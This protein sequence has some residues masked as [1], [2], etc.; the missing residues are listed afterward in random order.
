M[1]MKKRVGIGLKIILWASTLSLLWLIVLENFV[2][3]SFKKFISN[4]ENNFKTFES[5]T[6]KGLEDSSNNFLVKIG[7]LQTQNLAEKS[8]LLL[9]SNPAD[10][11]QKL[12]EIC[13]N[14]L[15]KD[16]NIAYLIVESGNTRVMKFRNEDFRPL[17]SDPAF[18]GDS[19][20][21]TKTQGVSLLL[22]SGKKILEFFA[23]IDANQAPS[24][25]ME[26][27]SNKEDSSKAMDQQT[28]HTS[29]GFVRV[30]MTYDALDCGIQLNQKKLIANTHEMHAEL[31]QAVHQEQNKFLGIVVLMALIILLALY[32]LISK[33]LSPFAILLRATQGI[34]KGNLG[35]K[36]EIY[37][38]DEIGDLA[39]NFNKMIENLKK[40]ILKIREA[41][42]RIT[43]TAHQI[44]ASSDE[45]AMGAS[46]QSSSV[47]E[48]TT[49]VEELANTAS[50]ISDNTKSVVLIADT[51][52]K[53]ARDG[54]Q[55]ITDALH[56]IEDAKEKVET[57]AKKIL[58]LNE[59][60]QSIGTI[61][62]IIDSILDQTNM[63]ALNAA[64]E[65]ARAGEAGRGFAVVAAEVRKLAERSSEATEEIRQLI[66]EIQTETHS[67]ILA[68]EAGTKGV[69][70]VAGLVKQSSFSIKEISDM[71][72]NT[73]AAAREI[74]MGIQQQ[75]AASE[76]VVKSME[77]INEVT[78]QFEAITQ[79]SLA[80]SNEL[81]D[82]AH[83]LKSAV[84]EFVLEEK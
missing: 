83:L 43:S 84:D 56:G 55:L 2:S 39:Q 59:K 75:Q 27:L 50:Q 45:Q 18:L 31:M 24:L 23:P 22:A 33:M 76:Q 57:V 64:I 47:T 37:S 5:I 35:T 13:N 11:Q 69:E 54:N 49:T 29:L 4:V 46:T 71:I 8:K 14:I 28:R 44:R 10:I 12:S 53:K 30:G 77:N 21:G 16:D 51:T 1:V 25:S 67:T 38:N 80:S 6:G 36:I 15:K 70:R 62:K 3:R 17:I 63:L 7:Q 78:K 9:L 74:S 26:D 20:L 61:T 79:Q 60:S 42:L 68:T 72:H 52:A 66:T 41:S 34:A 32:V 73:N 40:L 65:A 48:T 81:A 19:S 58:A 82:L